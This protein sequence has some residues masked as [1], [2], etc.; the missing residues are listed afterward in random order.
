VVQAVCKHME[1]RVERSLRARL[2][3]PNKSAQRQA[4]ILKE[5]FLENLHRIAVIGLEY[6]FT[7]LAQLALA[8]LRNDFFVLEA[9]RIKNSYVRWLGAW[10]GAAALVLVAA[11]VAINSS[12]FDWKWGH[13][14]RNFLLAGC[15]AAAG[16]WA[17]FS[18]RQVQFS[19]DDLVMMEENSLD[20]PV[21][22]LFVFVLTM[23]A[24]LLFWNSAINIEIGGLKTSPDVFRGSGSVALLIGLFAGLSER[25]LATAISGRA[26]A[27][28]KGI[29]GAA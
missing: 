3:Y 2:G 29:G 19:F 8:E 21:R 27:L 18:I 15:G 24:C 17:S 25:A 11:Y 6:E 10:A 9:G 22:V 4:Q 7:E 20:P 28:F 1:Q 12:F 16:T 26:A 23:A 13:D 14:H 5:E